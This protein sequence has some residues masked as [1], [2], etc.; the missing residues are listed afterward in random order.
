MS[1][2]RASAVPRQIGRKPNDFASSLWRG[3]DRGAPG[4]HLRAHAPVPRRRPPEQLPPPARARPSPPAEADLPALLALLGRADDEPDIERALLRQP[5][6]ARAAQ[7]R[8]AVAAA[9]ERARLVR[10]LGRF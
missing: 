2:G 1:A 9:P 7:A 4:S 6:A 10:L 3:R 8:L 5:A